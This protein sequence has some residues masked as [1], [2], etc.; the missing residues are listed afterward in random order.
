MKGV[1][2]YGD[3]YYLGASKLNLIIIE[4]I[5]KQKFR[6]FLQTYLQLVHVCDSIQ[7]K[8]NRNVRLRI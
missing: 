4:V 6:C 7:Q 3:S 1:R 8:Y 2:K 5:N